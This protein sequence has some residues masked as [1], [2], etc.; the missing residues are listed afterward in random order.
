VP[1]AGFDS[2]AGG[3]VGKFFGTGSNVGPAADDFIG[4]CGGGAGLERC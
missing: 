1:V 2:A 4:F 3:G